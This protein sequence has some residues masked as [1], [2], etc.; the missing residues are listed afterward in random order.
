M[1]L[2]RLVSC[3][4]WSF[5]F[6]SS[7]WL[8]VPVCNSFVQFL[9]LRPN[10]QDFMCQTDVTYNRNTYS[11][12]SSYKLTDTTFT[13]S[14]SWNSPNKVMS[15]QMDLSSNS[16]KMAAST[17]FSWAPNQKVHIFF[18]YAFLQMEISVDS[19]FKTFTFFLRIF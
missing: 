6:W 4:G 3:F 12:K 16:G 8:M 5:L 1:M 18:L 14:C 15:Y 13:T 10:P 11:L 2:L 9:F 7:R 19:C 17:E